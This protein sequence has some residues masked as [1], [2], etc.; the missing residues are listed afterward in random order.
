[1]IKRFDVQTAQLFMRH[2]NSDTTQRYN[3]EKEEQKRIARDKLSA[4]N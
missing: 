4:L 1:M 2:E 3:M